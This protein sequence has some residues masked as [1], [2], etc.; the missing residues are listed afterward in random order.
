MERARTR[1]IQE[2]LRRR[3]AERSRPQPE[4]EYFDRLL[5]QY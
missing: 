1:A 3:E 2:E 5:R 4:L